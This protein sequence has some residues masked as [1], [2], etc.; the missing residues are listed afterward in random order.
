MATFGR[1]PVRTCCGMQRLASVESQNSAGEMHP[2]APPAADG[3]FLSST[4]LNRATL[5]QTLAHLFQL[6][7]GKILTAGLKDGGINL[8]LKLDSASLADVTPILEKQPDY[9][10]YEPSR[11]GER[12]LNARILIVED[13]QVSRL[14]LRRILEQMPGCQVTEATTG[15]DALA[16]LNKGPLPDLCISDL[17]MPEMD[18]FAFL[19]EIRASPALAHL[20][21]MLCTA[22]TDRD[23]VLRAADLQVCRY[24]FKPYNPAD[25]RTKVR[26]TIARTVARQCQL[27]QEFQNR[28][29]LRPEAAI[30]MLKN[31]GQQFVQD[32]SFCRTAIATGKRHAVSLTL[33][34]LKGLSLAIQDEALIRR[35][36]RVQRD[37]E[38][39]ELASILDG[40]DSLSEEGKRLGKLA[41]RFRVTLENKK[42]LLEE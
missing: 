4:A 27:L 19:R 13:T 38:G 32:V 39:N 15:H 8:T 35:M 5:S 21:V 26:E 42:R 28:V 10:P 33:Q 18:G 2:L 36:E 14:L 29:G 41:D 3:P 25:I 31:V 17:S 20:D 40:F 1:Y 9:Q 23:T 12:R 22:T 6:L 7:P 34:A 37:F 24:L 16:I 30:E 11:T